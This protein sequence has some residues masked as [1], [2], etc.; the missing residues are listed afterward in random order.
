VAA[1][2][3]GDDESKLLRE[4]G[5]LLEFALLHEVDATLTDR[6]SQY[7]SFYVKYFFT[8]YMLRRITLRT[9][10]KVE[11]IFNVKTAGVTFVMFTV[12]LPP[13]LTLQS[14]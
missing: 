13:F 3:L 4:F 10:N 12:S 6:R 14:F 1:P 9:H 7:F 11:V 8:A 5:E 2:S